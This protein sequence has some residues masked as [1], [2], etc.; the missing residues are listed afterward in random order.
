[1]PWRFDAN[2]PYEDGFEQALL[3]AADSPQVLEIVKRK[4]VEIQ[5]DP[6]ANYPSVVG[7]KCVYIAKTGSSKIRGVDVGP[8]LIV[9]TLSEREKLIQ[10]VFICKAADVARKVEGSTMDTIGRTLSEA[11]E[12]ALTRAPATTPT[13]QVLLPYERTEI[14][15]EQIADAVRRTVGREKTGRNTR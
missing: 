2:N 14:P 11:I 6:K 4:C 5:R 10:R 15:E 7:G 8:L 12:A 1:M 9:Y 3:D 13:Q